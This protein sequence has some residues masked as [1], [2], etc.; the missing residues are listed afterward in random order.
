[1]SN[2]TLAEV[3]NQIQK[4]WSPM[5][6]Q[7]LRENTLLASLVNK[8]YSGSI[9]KGG[10]TVYVSQVNAPTG[11]LL[12]VGSNADSFTPDALST[13]RISIQ[14]N[15][16][17]V[18]SFQF[19]DLVDL[20]SQIGDA[21]SDIRS[22]LKFAVEKQINDYLY[23]LVAPSAS[24]PDHTVGS[25]ADM[26][27]AQLAG[28]RL[29]AAKAK[30]RQDKPWYLLADPSYYSDILKDT[31]L[32]SSHYGASD[33][34]MINGQVSLQRFGFTILEDNSRATDKALAF[35]PDFMHLVMQKEPQFKISDLHANKQFGYVISVDVIF[36][37]ALGIDGDVKHIEVT[38]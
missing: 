26:N 24:N 33:A 17:A 9:S 3:T 38:A 12:T 6:A 36:G 23:S 18:A 31:T 4:F 1:M 32:S 35:S 28:L 37:A 21:D 27:A 2:T 5:F 34:P 16:R 10:D 25:V 11:Q 15:K 14:A 8:D 7:E 13:S 22:A 29:L 19:E 20:Q 30:W